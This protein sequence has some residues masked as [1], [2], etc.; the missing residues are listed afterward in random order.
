[1]S[2]TA[3][4]QRKSSSTAR[5]V[6]AKA[7]PCPSPQDRRHQDR[8]RST[9]GTRRKRPQTPEAA[10][11]EARVA[12]RVAASRAAQHSATEAA[13]SGPTHQ[14]FA[15]AHAPVR[16]EP[17]E[18]RSIPPTQSET[19]QSEASG[20]FDPKVYRAASRCI[21]PNF[22]PM[23]AASDDDYFTTYDGCEDIS[24]PFH[25][26]PDDPDFNPTATP[27]IPTSTPTTT[28]TDHPPLPQSLPRT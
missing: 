6:R 26:D 10:A 24:C 25:G 14:P 12:E 15:S 19:A 4:G 3:Y 23:L 20:N 8:R 11:F 22:D 21:D 7:G 13:Q 9:N 16:P 27:T 2:D 28:T 1:M 18:G 17:V 5:M